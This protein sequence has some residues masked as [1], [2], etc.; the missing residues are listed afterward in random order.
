M[1]DGT[2]A[3]ID[4]IRIAQPEQDVVITVT[5][6]TL[7]VERNTGTDYSIRMNVAKRPLTITGDGT[8]VQRFDGTNAIWYI[9]ENITPSSSG[10][11]FFVETDG[12][13]IEEQ[14]LTILVALR[15]RVVINS[16]ASPSAASIRK[17]G[18]GR[19]ILGGNNGWT[20]NTTIHDGRLQMASDNPLSSS[21]ALIFNNTA[22]LEPDGF[23]AGFSTVEI[24]GLVKFD[25][26]NKAASN[27][28]FS[29]SSSV[30]W[31]AATL[32]INNYTEGANTVRFGTD[33]TGLTSNQLAVI[34]INGISNLVLDADGYLLT[35]L[36][37]IPEPPLHPIET[38]SI[39][40]SGSGIELS[41]ESTTNGQ[42]YSVE[43]KTNL[44]DGAWLN[45]TNI[46]GTG[47]NG[48][49]IPMP[50]HL[51]KAFYQVISEGF[52]GY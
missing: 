41:L 1:V 36:P 27:I 37:V 39:T 38:I 30:A 28:A 23:D 43:Y 25:F 20:G 5:N 19:L 47:T 32:T 12:F 49:A 22:I 34:T 45:Y 3:W 4:E 9:N 21:S 42:I 26:K 7:N 8:F 17:T 46:T 11:N 15:R 18:N 35:E 31:G 48:V 52:E 50:T 29:N 44:L 6:G 24:N 16:S 40:H 51:P 33:N 13:L 2:N 10:G 14:E